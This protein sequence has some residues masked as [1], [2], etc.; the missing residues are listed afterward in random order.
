MNDL[1]DNKFH[2]YKLI[3]IFVGLPASGKSYTSFQLNQY[4]N[5]IGYNTQIFNCGEYRRKLNDKNQSSIFFDSKNKDLVQQRETFLNYALFDLNTFLTINNGKIAILDATNSTKERRRKIIETLNLFD[6]P[7][8]IIF[9]EN[10]TKDKDII[11]K[12]IL[13]KKNSKDYINFS[14]EDMKKDFTERLNYYK[15]I[16]ETLLE[17]ESLNYIKIFDCGKTVTYHNI[18]G[19]IESLLLTFLIN[20]RVYQKKIFITRHGQSLYNLEERIGGDPELSIEGQ[21]YA[22]KLFNYISLYYKKDD[23][24]IFTSN[25]K[26]TKITAKYFI[27]NDYNVIHKDILNEIHGGVCENLTYDYVKK[28]MPELHEARSKDK[29]N[30]KYPEGESYYDL[31]IRLKEFILELNRL[32]RPVLIICHN[33]IVRVLYSYFFSILHEDIPHQ[34]IQLHNLDCITNDTYFYKKESVLTYS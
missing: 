21:K 20:F 7:K 5:W 19:Y 28:T 3:I 12:N 34:N 9:I 11:D 25:L 14:I 15:E 23:I 32:E 13:F 8:K 18:N 30:F 2:Q 24:I 17:E 1:S 29:F 6:Y 33:A 4:F 22:L 16:Y 10:I 31:I 26:R 27:E